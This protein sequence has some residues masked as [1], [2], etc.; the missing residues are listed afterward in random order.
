MYVLP[1]FEGLIEDQQIESKY[2]HL[3]FNDEGRL[4]IENIE[5]EGNN[6][7]SQG[8]DIIDSNVVNAIISNGEFEEI[9]YWK[10][11]D[12]LLT[13]NSIRQ[14][15]ELQLKFTS[16]EF[17]IVSP[18]K[19]EISFSFIGAENKNLISQVNYNNRTYFYLYDGK[20]LTNLSI[21]N[22]QKYYSF[23]MP[24]MLASVKT[25]IRNQ[26]VLY[27]KVS[28][29]FKKTEFN[30][31]GKKISLTNYIESKVNGYFIT[32]FFENNLYLFY[33]GSNNNLLTITKIE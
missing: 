29:S 24:E 3:L 25:Q 18:S 8:I 2:V 12:S 23:I 26:Y 5:L 21:T 10:Y 32:S 31:Q 17:K 30:L 6:I 13:F 22:Q 33:S 19:P 15:E 20:K 4:G 9:H 14:L 1:Q 27:D 28:E 11:A 7:L 16:E